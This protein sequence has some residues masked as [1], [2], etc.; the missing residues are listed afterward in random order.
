[1]TKI[2]IPESIRS[3]EDFTIE[4]D[5][6]VENFFVAVYESPRATFDDKD[7]EQKNPIWNGD[8]YA[9]GERNSDQKIT[10]TMKRGPDN[11]P[12]LYGKYLVKITLDDKTTD[13]FL[14]VLPA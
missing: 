1:M 7:K 13:K 10:V 9:I 3:G 5:E 11:K 6:P 14:N 4:I 12:A 8:I 2:K